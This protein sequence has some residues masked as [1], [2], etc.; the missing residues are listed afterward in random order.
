MPLTR[1]ANS[2]ID[3]V[4]DQPQP[5]ADEIVKYLGSDLLLYRADHRRNLWRSRRR[6]GT[7]SSP[8]PPTHSARVSCL[9]QGMAFAAQPE[10]SHRSHA[11][12]PAARSSGG[13]APCMSATTLTGSGLLAL[14]LAHGAVSMEDA[15]R[16]AH[17]DEDWQI[18]Q[19]GEDALA[20][21]RQ[22][23]RL[24]EFAAAANVLHLVTD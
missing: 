23:F 8:G 13:S 5:V 16:A 10:A 3:G 17:V 4:A 18:A 19:W 2:I 1:L 7:R 22:D 21:Q 11:R 12:G 6:P 20:R 15:W 9:V 24:A 14:A